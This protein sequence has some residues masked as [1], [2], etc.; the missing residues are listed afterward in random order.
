MQ[1]TLAQHG[2]IPILSGL[3]SCL[4]FLSIY[5]KFGFEWIINNFLTYKKLIFQPM[6][7]KSL[8]TI[9]LLGLPIKSPVIIF[10]YKWI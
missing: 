3:G 1:E 10:L 8:N 4:F 7:I 6:N 5:F 9:T 2:H